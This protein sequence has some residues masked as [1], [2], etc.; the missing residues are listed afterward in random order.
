MIRI[1]CITLP[2]VFTEVKTEREEAMGDSSTCLLLFLSTHIKNM[3]YYSDSMKRSELL[4]YIKRIGV[5]NYEGS[6]YDSV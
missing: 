2:T 4:E 1:L 5:C 3:E 6:K